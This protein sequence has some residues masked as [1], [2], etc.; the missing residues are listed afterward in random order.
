[1][2]SPAHTALGH[3]QR[4][5]LAE[6]S[7]MQAHGSTLLLLYLLQVTDA[8]P[9]LSASPPCLTCRLSSSLSLKLCL[10]ATKCLMSVA[11]R[12]FLRPQTPSK[13]NPALSSHVT[14]PFQPMQPGK[15][16]GAGERIWG[17]GPAPLLT[18]PVALR[19]LSLL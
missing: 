12:M 19:R 1:M 11:T 8:V 15:S 3:R 14:D 5:P 7:D 4:H 2:L 16:R 13:L 17:Q 6:A 18:Q 10:Q 9:M